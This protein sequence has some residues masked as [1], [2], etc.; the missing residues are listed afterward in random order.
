MLGMILFA[1]LAAGGVGFGVWAMM[2]KNAEVGKLNTQI[3]DLKKQIT[4]LKKQIPVDYEDEEG[5]ED[6]EPADVEVEDV[7]T[8][9][10]IYVGEW[11]LKIKI[12]D[13]LSMVGYNFGNGTYGE[14]LSVA[15]LKNGVTGEAVYKYTYVEDYIAGQI[16][17]SNSDDGFY[18]YGALV[19]TDD[20][21]NNYYFTGPQADM[22][23]TEEE[24]AIWKESA[25]I[26]KEMLTNPDN[27]S[28]I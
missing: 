24:T 3:A 28:K 12:P 17:R 27:Y 9:D 2:D 14:W 26:V 16:V 19:Y 5:T 1:L 22:G 15:G 11:G 21:Q 25:E 18:P 13:S 6:E 4:Q 10:Y 8:E 7:N 23:S 20:E